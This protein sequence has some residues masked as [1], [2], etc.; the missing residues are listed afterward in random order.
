MQITLP[1]E[2]TRQ[3]QQ[4][5]AQSKEFRTVEEYV[6]YVLTVVMQQTTQSGSTQSTTTVQSPHSAPLA[7]HSSPS[8]TQPD[9]AYSAEQEK[10]VQQR[11]HDLGYLD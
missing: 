4:H 1:D 3:L 6:T 5:I 11:L 10:A 7:S 2:L 8:S 9:P